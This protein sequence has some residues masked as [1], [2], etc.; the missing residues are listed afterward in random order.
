MSRRASNISRHYTWRLTAICVLAFAVNLAHAGTPAST[1]APSYTASG[2]VNAATGLSGALSPNAITSLYGTNLAW[3]TQAVTAGDLVGGALPTALA[4]VTVYVDNIVSALFFVSP[5]QINFLIPYEI[6]ATSITVFVERQGITGPVVTIP[7]GPVSP[8]FFQ[9]NGNF[10]VAQHA[11]GSLISPT[12][13]AQGGEIVVLYA[14]GLGHTIPDVPPGYIV[15]TATSILAA[16]QLQILINGDPCAAGSILYAGLTP[17]FAGLYQIN[18]KLP[19][20]LPPDGTIQMSIGAESSP[21]AVQ[22]YTQ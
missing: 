19:A 13:P 4:G 22:L 7:L 14:A 12:A 18:L 17:G 9:W 1:T 16:A 10:A 20:D 6:E 3:A 11:D 2:I 15:S 5:G 8:G 21:A